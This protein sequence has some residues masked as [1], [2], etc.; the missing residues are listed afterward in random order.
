MG[1]EELK[2]HHLAHHQLMS[3]PRKLQQ[4]SVHREPPEIGLV[5]KLT[6]TLYVWVELCVPT[7]HIALSDIILPNTLFIVYEL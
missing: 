4:L 6:G 3:Q 5:E 2:R 7:L 1:R